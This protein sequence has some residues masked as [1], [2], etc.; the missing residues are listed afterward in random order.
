MTVE[1]EM[2]ELQNIARRIDAENQAR[3]RNSESGRNF[4]AKAWYDALDKLQQNADEKSTLKITRVDS[5]QV[6]TGPIAATLTTYIV[7]YVIPLPGVYPFRIEVYENRV[8]V[9]ILLTRQP[10]GVSELLVR[11]DG[12][13][14]RLLSGTTTYFDLMAETFA[15]YC[16]ECN[17]M[18]ERVEEAAWVV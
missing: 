8:E 9:R 6:R 16:I 15:R 2:E 14:S 17:R 1:A 12:T 5:K 13:F 3:A 4:A 10:T 11:P 7:E 18:E